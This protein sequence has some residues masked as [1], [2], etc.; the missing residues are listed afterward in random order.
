MLPRIRDSRDHK[1]AR[2]KARF[3]AARIARIPFAA[4]SQH[5]FGV[6][7]V[8]TPPAPPATIPETLTFGVGFEFEHRKA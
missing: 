5:T 3:L 8:I 1:R 6:I 7:C 2:R 4:N